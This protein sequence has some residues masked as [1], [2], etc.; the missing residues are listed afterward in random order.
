MQQVTVYVKEEDL[1]QNIKSERGVKASCVLQ[2]TPYFS[3]EI[4]VPINQLKT[5]EEGYLYV[6]LQSRM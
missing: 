5:D 1:I 2:R 3:T 4:H 6:R